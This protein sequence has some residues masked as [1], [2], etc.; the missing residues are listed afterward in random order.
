MSE[1]FTAEEIDKFDTTRFAYFI[2]YRRAGRPVAVAGLLAKTIM[3]KV[4]GLPMNMTQF[5]RQK[6]FADILKKQAVNGADDETLLFGIAKVADI[7]IDNVVDEDQARYWSGIFAEAIE[8]GGEFFAEPEPE[9]TAVTRVTPE[10]SPAPATMANHAVHMSTNSRGN[11]EHAS[12]AVHMATF[13]HQTKAGRSDVVAGLV[14]KAMYPFAWTQLGY[15]QWVTDDAGRA[16]VEEASRLVAEHVNPDNGWTDIQVRGLLQA[17]FKGYGGHCDY[18]SYPQMFWT[19]HLMVATDP[20]RYNIKE[21]VEE[22]DANMPLVDAPPKDAMAEQDPEESPIR[23]AMRLTGLQDPIAAARRMVEMTGQ[24]AP[25]KGSI[26]AMVADGMAL[27]AQSDS[28]PKPPVPSFV[29]GNYTPDEY[30]TLMQLPMQDP[31]LRFYRVPTFAAMQIKR[32]LIDQKPKPKRRWF[33]R[34]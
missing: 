22:L 12:D 4:E 11:M 8:A 5:V 28:E 33:G 19:C 31:A 25:I 23:Q 3:P 17:T 30:W 13:I 10:P 7:L 2:Q 34:S 9:P 32:D 29:Q 24:A 27:H 14:V 21:L 1:H 20:D 16:E 6:A 15:D 26:D 18:Q